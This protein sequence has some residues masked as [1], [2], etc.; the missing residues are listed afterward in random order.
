MNLVDA[1]IFAGELR[2]DLPTLDLHGFFP[3]EALEKLELFLYEQNQSKNQIVK[4]IYG[5]GTGKLKETVLKYLKKH[6]LVDTIKDK[7]GFAI[8]IINF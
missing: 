4:I 3:S 7:G 8:L 6:P 5:A 2:D 1:K